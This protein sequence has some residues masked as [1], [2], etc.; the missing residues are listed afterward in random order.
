MYS[1]TQFWNAKYDLA[2]SL[3]YNPASPAT[4]VMMKFL[5]QILISA[6]ENGEVTP[7]DADHAIKLSG[8]DELSE[9]DKKYVANW[10][11]T[12]GERYVG[13]LSRDQNQQLRRLLN[14]CNDLVNYGRMSATRDIAELLFNR[15]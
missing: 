2:C 11:N 14:V 13:N 10:M 15:E 3:L 1:N 9:Q 5:R 7:A 6:I 12:V 4:Q 8:A